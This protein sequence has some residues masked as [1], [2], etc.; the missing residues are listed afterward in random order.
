MLAVDAIETV[1]AFR[2]DM[3]AYQRHDL[4]ENKTLVFNA[5]IDEIRD[6]GDRMGFRHIYAERFSNTKWVRKRLTKFPEI[7]FHINNIIKIDELEDVFCLSQE[8]CQRS[9]YAQPT[10]IFMEVQMKNTSL[11]PRVTSK[12]EG[13]KS[14]AIIKGDAYNGI[15]MKRVIG[16]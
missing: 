14:F 9:G 16:I 3:K 2:D 15:P 1:R 4:M 12:M 13:I 8:L 11:L 6:L 5:L 10:D 7:F